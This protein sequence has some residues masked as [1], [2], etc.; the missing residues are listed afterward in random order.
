[1]FAG[2]STGAILATALASGIHPSEL[3][4]FYES[5]SDEIFSGG[6]TKRLEPLSEVFGTKYDNA[7]LRRL[8]QEVYGDKELGSC[9]KD[10]VVTCLEVMDGAWKPRIFSNLNPEDRGLKIVDVLL[11][12]TAAPIY[13]PIYE[14]KVDGGMAMNNPTL[15]A[16]AM[17]RKM[18]PHLDMRSLRVLS[19]STGSCGA[20]Y[21]PF[22]QNTHWG[23]VEWMKEGRLVDALFEGVAGVTE[24]ECD[25]LLD[26]GAYRRINPVLAEPIALDSVESIPKLKDLGW[27]FDLIEHTRWLGECYIHEDEDFL[28]IDD[29]DKLPVPSAS[30]SRDQSS[31]CPLL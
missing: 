13:F 7:S 28:M 9:S 21:P 12:A 8:L 3:V 4:H 29:S 1:M 16:I 17:S 24:W 2:T 14:G 23:V 15:C 25:A 6:W 20:K 30:I 5:K 18:L 27:S 31:F 19:I 10:V 11:A 22:A 26:H